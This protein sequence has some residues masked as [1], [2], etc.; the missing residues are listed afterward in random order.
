MEI[1]LATRGDAAFQ[2][3]SFEFLAG[4]AERIDRLWM[5]TLWD[6]D[7][8]R[9][10]HV[11]AQRAVFTTLNGLAIERMLVPGMRD[12]APDLER[13]ADSVLATLTEK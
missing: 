12:V 13:L 5:G 9:A 4:I 3:R 7:S 11:E 2:D 6:V 8:S 10:R 1:L